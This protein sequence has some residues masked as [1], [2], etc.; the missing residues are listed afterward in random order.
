MLADGGEHYIDLSNDEISKERDYPYDINLISKSMEK[1]KHKYKEE[2]NTTLPK[3]SN[4]ALKNV[5]L[6]Y[7]PD[8][9]FNTFQGTDGQASEITMEL[10][11][12]E[13]ETLTREKVEDG[14]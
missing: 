6:A 5:K 1:Q 14:F 4:C 7:G 12:V 2:I 8:G 11:F 9:M 10:Q 13:L 3:I